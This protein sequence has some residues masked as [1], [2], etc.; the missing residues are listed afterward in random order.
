[1]PE[2]KSKAMSHFARHLF[3]GAKLYSDRKA[4]KE[5]LN[6]QL[7]RMRKS[8]IRLSFSYSDIDQLRE[9]LEKTIHAERKFA[10]FFQVDDLEIKKLKKE[11]AWQQQQLDSERTEKFRLMEENK[12]RI[13]ALEEKVEGIKSTL[14]ALIM[15]KI[16]RGQRLRFLEKK[17]SAEVPDH[18]YLKN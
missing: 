2:K 12:T 8:I 5:E 15:E 9:K 11:V 6:E 14:N 17:I 18:S 1:M 16:R 13:K 10:K 3:L 7:E 4:A